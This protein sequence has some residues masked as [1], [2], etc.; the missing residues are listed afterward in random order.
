MA[1]PLGVLLQGGNKG[2]IIRCLCDQSR[3][4]I[5]VRVK[6]GGCIRGRVYVSRGGLEGVSHL[7]EKHP[8]VWPP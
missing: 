6:E 2:T 4:Y 8:V 3:G 5:R 1:R 7:A